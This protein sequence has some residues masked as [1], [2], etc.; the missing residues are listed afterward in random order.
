MTE[1][2][3]DISALIQRYDKSNYLR[4][5]E[6]FPVQV[7]DAYT[8]EIPNLPN[9]RESINSI[10]VAGMGGSAIGGELIQS[11]YEHKLSVPLHVVR[12]YELPAYFQNR[13]LVCI[14]SYS[15]NT[16]ETLS[17]YAQAR[18]RNAHIVCITTGG[19]LAEIARQHGDPIIT[20]PAG[21]Q[22][23][24][25]LG[26]SV[27]PL[28][29]TLSHYNIISIQKPEIDETINILKDLNAEYGT[30]NYTS[31]PPLRLAKDIVG[32]IP[33]IYTGYAPFNA[34]G[35]RWKCQ[36]NENAKVPSYCQFLPELS[37]NE[38]VGWNKEVTDH[39]GYHVV[40]L[41]DTDEHTQIKKRIEVTQEILANQNCSFSDVWSSGTGILARTFSLVYYGDYISF[42]LALLNKQDP[43]R[44]DNIN[45]LKSKL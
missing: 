45:Y 5:I 34:L 30:Q 35:T 11:L 9:A 2:N 31:S 40:F 22:P 41:R 6:E 13:S 16:E 4:F 3:V 25:A 7:H 37:H 28:M 17:A 10:A 14:S 1:K 44:I 36:L 42:Y 18:E 33:L 29:K 24:A 21:F 26:Y 20:I 43:S 19:T 12:N 15:G 8:L 27:F 32:K 39:T 23:R 38:I